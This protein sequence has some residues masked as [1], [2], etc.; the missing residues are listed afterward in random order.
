VFT[1]LH[2]ND[3]PGAFTRLQEMGVEPFLMASSTIG[4]LAQRLARRICTDCKEQFTP[5]AAIA[6]HFGFHDESNLPTFYKG[7]G[8]ESCGDT[9]YKGRVGVYEVL[10]MNEEVRRLVA[11]GAKSAEVR[12]CAIKNGMMTLQ[13]YGKWLI[14][15]GL[16]TAEAMTAVV[17]I[18]D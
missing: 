18:A 11:G 9:G 17:S 2:T 4:I 13:E 14:L 12:D 16:T 15:E 3:A 1:T 6:K 5:E 10:V 7:R 8:C